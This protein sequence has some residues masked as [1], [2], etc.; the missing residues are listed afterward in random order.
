VVPRPRA[1]SGCV[2]AHAGV[3]SVGPAPALENHQEG[4]VEKIWLK[5]YQKGV[6][7]EVDLAQFTSLKD[8]IEKSCS[9]Y[10]NLPRTCRLTA[11][12]G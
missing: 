9:K 1:R 3:I 10:K 8:I 5:Q 2:A 6:P 4:V 12:W 11:T 7:A